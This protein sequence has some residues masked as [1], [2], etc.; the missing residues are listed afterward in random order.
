[1]SSKLVASDKTKWAKT[2]LP[3]SAEIEKIDAV[4]QE[5]SGEPINKNIA[6]LLAQRGIQ[7]RAE[8]VKFFKP[9]LEDL[10]DPFLMKGMKEAVTR[11]ESAIAKKEKILVYGDYDVDGTTAVSVVYSVLKNLNA[12]AGFYIPD[13]YSEGYGISKKGVD[14]ASENGYSLVIALDCGIRAV[15]KID[16]ANQLGVDFIICDH[17][18]PGEK[19]P[20]AIAVLDPK[21]TDCNYP[22]K[23]LSGCGVGFKL[24]QA[25]CSQLEVDSEMLFEYLDLLAISIGADIVPITGENRILASFGL[26]K[27]F[28]NTR[29]GIDFLFKS[30]NYA[31]SGMVTITDLVFLIAPRINAAGRMDSGETAVRLL[32]TKDEKEASELSKLLE[33]SNTSRKSLDKSTTAEALTMIAEDEDLEKAAS[34]VVWN[35]GWHKGVIGIVASRLIEKYYRPTIVLTIKDGLAT[36]SARSVEGFNIHEALQECAHCIEQ[37]GGHPMAAGMSIKTENLKSFRKAFEKAVS[38]SILDDQKTP[39]IQVDMDLQLNEINREFY[40]LLRYFSP[41]GPGN[42]RPVFKTEGVVATP[43]TRTVGADNKHLKL[44]VAFGEK[45]VFNGIAFGLGHYARDLSMGKP[46]SMVYTLEENVFRGHRSLQLNVKDI[47]LEEEN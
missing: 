45:S 8:L 6:I 11:L 36:G 12:T 23:E 46:F 25:L 3:N 2:P 30:A 17:H 26:K 20:A 15:D 39:V 44:E 18:T 24:M 38:Q 32:T 37:F 22:Y 1:M 16:Y 21:Q 33:A 42:M 28:E 43:R 10:H 34:T 7:S 13:R 41:F 14:Y 40:K 5:L 27:M 47:K 9:K 31:N 29:P 19:V 4:W 35:D